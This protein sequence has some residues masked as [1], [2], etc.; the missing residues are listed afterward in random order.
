VRRAA[1][2]WVRFTMNSS[3]AIPTRTVEVV[4]TELGAALSNKALQ[5]SVGAAG[6]LWSPQLNA[7]I[8]TQTTDEP[9]WTVCRH[10]RD[11]H[12]GI[13]ERSSHLLQVD[14]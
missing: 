9:I 6:S 5:L 1:F 13:R 12:C 2:P 14:V 7:D 11:N 8:I 3:N 4:T 10:C